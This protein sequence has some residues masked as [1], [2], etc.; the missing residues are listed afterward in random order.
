MNHL[1]LW[2]FPGLPHFLGFVDKGLEQSCEHIDHRL[3]DGFDACAADTTSCEFH[4]MSKLK[5]H[6][7]SLAYRES[8]LSFEPLIDRGREGNGCAEA[9][10]SV[11]QYT[12]HDVRITC[13]LL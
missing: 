10:T 8:Q 9:Q 3:I 7:L 12:M 13:S 1:A 2:Q 11:R 6:K 5:D 4:A